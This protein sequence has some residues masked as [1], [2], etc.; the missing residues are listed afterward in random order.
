ML[1]AP[2]G[3]HVTRDVSPPATTSVGRL[4]QFFRDNPDR[5][6]DGRR[7]SAIAGSYAWRT[8]VSDLRREPFVMTVINRQ[9]RQ[10][11]PTGKPFV[12]S[13]YM[14]VSESELSTICAGAA[15]TG[16]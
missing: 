16:A 2:A 9:V 5:W 3:Y 4:A 1:E 12:V 15:A 11:S 14:F 13:E 8:R 10:K 7:L 6:I